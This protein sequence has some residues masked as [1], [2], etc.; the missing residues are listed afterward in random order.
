MHPP[1]YKSLLFD[2]LCRQDEDGSRHPKPRHQLQTHRDD[3]HSPSYAGG[4][5]NVQCN[6]GNV[7]QNDFD[8]KTFSCVVI[9][10]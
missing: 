9:M 2:S 6:V 5:C 3:Q 4:K 1:R 10:C 8:I 7:F